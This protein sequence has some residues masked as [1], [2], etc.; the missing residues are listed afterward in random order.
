MVFRPSVAVYDACVLYPF[1]TRN[2]IV[3]MAVDRVAEA[4]WTD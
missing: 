4:R 2:V 1:H 3:Q